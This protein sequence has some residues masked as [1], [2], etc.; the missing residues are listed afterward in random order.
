MKKYYLCVNTSEIL[1]KASAKIPWSHNIL[2]IDKVKKD[3]Q[4]IWYME[5]TLEN[6]WGYYTLADQI[7]YD[8]YSRQILGD[9]PNNFSK[10]LEN[11]QDDL[12]YE[13]MKDPYI[14]DI[15]TLKDGYIEKE[16]ENATKKK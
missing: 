7:K 2:I 13:M 4:R 10:T 11:P 6:G 12:A 16:V 1:Q 14:F 9:K 8:T 3:E 5:Q 15:T